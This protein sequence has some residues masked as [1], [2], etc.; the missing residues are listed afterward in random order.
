M[1]KPISEVLGYVRGGHALRVAASKL[2]EVMLASKATGL[3]GELT[4]KIKVVPDK[5]DDRLLKLFPEVK[6]K[7][8][9]K[10]LAE[11]YVF[12][13]GNGNISQEDPAQ[14]DL[15]EERRQQGV[16]TLAAGEA[17]LSQVGR[18]GGS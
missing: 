17:A 13:D 3:V 6:A 9:Q 16:A 2:A 12:I 10:G 1:A 5:T 4:L 18:G 15:L 11:G 14:M 8:P 7:I